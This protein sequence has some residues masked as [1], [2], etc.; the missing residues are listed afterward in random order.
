MR[1]AVATVQVPFISGGAEVL[2]AGLL[3][4]LRRA[5][6]ASEIVTL[7]F[8][9][10]PD[11]EVDRAMRVWEEEDFARLNL[12]EPDLVVCLKFPAYGLRHPR[13]TTWLLHQH[14]PAYETRISDM[15]ADQRVLAQRVR[16]FDHRH[17]NGTRLF[18]ISRR[19]SDR[20]RSSNR[21]DSVALYHPPFEPE[22]LYCG[23]ALPY[24]FF[25]SRVESAKRQ[26]LLIRAMTLV[27]SPV[28]ALLAG[29]GGQIGRMRELVGELGL[30]SRVRLLGSVGWDELRA[31]YARALAIFFG[32]KDEDYGYVT[33]EAMLSRKP[34]ITCTDSGGPL[35][36]VVDGETGCVVAPEP[37]AVAEAI[38]ALWADRARARRIG[39]AGF[40]RYRVLDIRWEHVVER[41]AGAT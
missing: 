34:V 7:P 41:L 6:H 23:E 20:L 27:K 29:E 36:F 24:I 16:E 30:Q 3:D 26:E 11:T 9:F 38:D 32:P 33:L 1:V 4:A 5:G 2:A 31:L 28:G 18:T 40:D 37:V 21:L 19:V 10:F 35:E 39:E 8:R 17:L 14:R 13:K 25:P 12:Y 22:K 15:T